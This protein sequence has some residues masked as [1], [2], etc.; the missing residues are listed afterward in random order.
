MDRKHDENISAKV[1]EYMDSETCKP[2]VRQFSLDNLMDLDWNRVEQLQVRPLGKKIDDREKEFTG[3]DEEGCH[4]NEDST[5]V[6]LVG[7][8]EK[9]VRD[10]VMMC[11]L[12][13][14]S[15]NLSGCSGLTALPSME[16]LTQL[17]SLN[18][19]GCSGL[20]ALP[21][22]E[23]LTQLTSLNL[24]GC[25]GLTA[26]PGME[27]LTQLTYLNLS[28][29]RNLAHLPEGIRRMRK[30][31]RLDLRGLFLRELPDWLPEIAE[32][33]SMEFFPF[34]SGRNFAIVYLRG[35]VVEGV[36]MS[37]FTQPYEVVVQWFEERKRGRTVP[38]NE[39]KVVFLGD[40]EAGKSHIV[41]RLMNDG[42]QTKDF[43]NVSTPGIAIQDKEYQLGNRT[44]RVH[45]WDFGGQEI[46]HSMHRLFL[47]RRTVYVVVVNAR[48]DTQ[49]E[50][51]RYWFQNINSIAPG[52]PTLLVLNK[53]DQNP[54][55]SVDEL[56]LRKRYSGLR[57]VIRMSALTF[58]Q[59]QFNRELTDRLLDTIRS[60]GYLDTVWPTSWMQVKDALQSM[61]S[62]YIT[63]DQY[64]RICDNNQA[65]DCGHELLHWFN[66]LGVSFCYSESRRL[67][68]YV[69][70]R[71]EWITNAIYSLIFNSI[72]GN[73]NG[74]IYHDEIYR[75]LTQSENGSLNICRVYPHM[76]YSY[77]DVEY[78]LDVMR[79]FQLSFQLER[80]REMIPMLCSRNSSPV[81]F[82]YEDDEDTIEFRMVYDFLPVN[83]IHRFMVEMRQDLDCDHVW[84]TGARFVSRSAGAS[85]IVCSDGDEIRIFVRS[86][87]NRRTAYRYLES[88][89]DTIQSINHAMGLREEECQIAYKTDGKTE[90]FDYGI[91][92]MSLEFGETM[93]F[94]KTRR[95]KIPIQDILRQTDAETRA[96]GEKLL[97][98]ILS[99]CMQ[100]QGHSMLWNA[101]EEERNRF[102]RDALMNFGYIVHDQ[103]MQGSSTFH[104]E[105][106]AMDLEIRLAADKPF[107]VFDAFTVRDA[108]SFRRYSE[109]YVQKMLN[110]AWKQQVLF[111][112]SYVECGKSDFSRMVRKCVDLLHEAYDG[113][114]SVDVNQLL[115]ECQHI[116]VAHGMFKQKGFP[117]EMY[118]VFVHTGS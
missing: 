97:R 1:H 78:V 25:S 36:D 62:A 96:D 70:L 48:D 101:E 37:I 91:L 61:E 95:R 6:L 49:N 3:E 8:T 113:I 81:V 64:Q 66:D 47:T 35:T 26:L 17:T 46:L 38:L 72:P 2:F 53:I 54:N 45:F 21:D 89:R 56:Y 30:L 116:A 104:R 110:Y 44:V 79:K 93:V 20:T 9:Q 76:H 19:S 106:I 74:I 69:I 65:G 13:L 82:E 67:R 4:T 63:G 55:A 39:I 58:S 98:S 109:R 14:T 85:A 117:V 32:H 84:Y 99:A 18:L 105:Y 118:F 16:M 107:A 103:T 27:M 43:P 88:I 22:M 112:A 42:G 33:F 7:A 29:C 50:R 94:S 68:D 73:Q 5:K 80:D 10:S 83:V 100:M 90:F 40:G 15:L 23:M 86:E 59:D 92:T 87:D 41:A 11:G 24:S 102:L 75:I 114:A 77:Q 115:P 34:R 31:R 57:D 111:L 71:P 60:M 52:T 28:G 108:L 51:A 12:Q